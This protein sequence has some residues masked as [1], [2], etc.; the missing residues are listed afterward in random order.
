MG[1][2]TK[3]NPNFNINGQAISDLFMNQNLDSDI[4]L[5]GN[6]GAEKYLHVSSKDLDPVYPEIK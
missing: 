4:R 3:E 5:S 2:S 1:I 6:I